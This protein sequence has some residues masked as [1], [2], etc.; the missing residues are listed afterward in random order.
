MQSLLVHDVE[1]EVSSSM[2]YVRQARQALRQALGGSPSLRHVL[3][4][5]IHYDTSLRFAMTLPGTLWVH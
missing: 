4:P 5:C 3:R 1:R 2:L